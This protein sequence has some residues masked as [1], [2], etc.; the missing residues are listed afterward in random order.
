[1]LT[2]VRLF[3]QP[4][5]EYGGETL[6]LPAERRCQLLALLALRRTWVSRGEIADLFWPGLSTERA[7]TN[8]R[9]VVHL[10]R[11]LPWASSLELQSGALRFDVRNDVHDFH[12]AIAE[13]RLDDALRSRR[14][15]L[16][17]GFDADAGTGW[18]TWLAHER[19]RLQAAWRDAA[20]ARLSQDV[21]AAAAID[22]S[23]RLVDADGLDEAALRA[24]MLA[25]LRDGQA[26][27][28]R[29]AYRDFVDRLHDELGLPPSVELRALHDSLPSGKDA[30]SRAG[31]A[32]A[33]SSEDGFVGRGVELRQIASLLAQP[34]CRLV[35]LVGPGGVGKSRLARRS[36]A[37]LA[38]QFPD[39][40]VFVALEDAA[41]AHDA[42][43]RIARELDVPVAAKGDPLDH[44]VAYLRD[45]AMLLVLDNVEH[46]ASDASLLERLLQSC[47][48]LR[49]IVT[50]RV[51]LGLALEWLLPL[52]G[53]PFPEPEDEDRAD[54]FDAVR[55]FVKAARRVQPAF[56]AAAERDAIV[57][58][59]RQVEGLPLALEIAAAWTR[60]LPCATIAAE[61][62]EGT[63]LLRSVDAARPARQASIEAVF[64]HSW[65]LLTPVERDVLARL[66][67]FRGGFTVEAARAV[68]GAA[69]PVLAALADKS[70][71][72]NAGK[73]MQL[74]PLVHQVAALRL[75]RNASAIA[76][77]RAHAEYFHRMLTRLQQP[78]RYGD[79]D[80]LV[81]IEDELA[82]C[83]SAW[84]WAIANG[85]SDMLRRSVLALLDFFE[86]RGRFVEGLALFREATDAASSLMASPTLIDAAIAHLEYRLDRHA[87]AEARATRVLPVAR[88]EHDDEAVLQCLKTL[89][90]CALAM[91]RH[92]VAKRFFQQSGRR[93]LAMADLRTAAGMLDNEALVDKA[94]GNYDDALRLSLESLSRH[95]RLGDA[96]GVALCLNNVGTLYLALGQ[97]QSARVN[98]Q[99][100]LELCD[101]QGIV[102]TRALVLA[103]LADVALQQERWEE[104]HAACTRAL[105]V[106]HHTSN[107]T[108]VAYL[109]LQY[110]QIALHRADLDGA[111][112][113]L[114]SGLSVAIATGRER[115]QL[116]A[117]GCFGEILAAQAEPG[118]ARQVLRFA[119]EHPLTDAPDREFF[120]RSLADL[121]AGAEA[122]SHKPSL[123]LGELVQR[124]VAETAIAYRPLI[125]TLRGA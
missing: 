14:G 93:A 18:T 79:H 22:L 115:L 58:I 21:D 110:V 3:G 68:A 83:R 117:V 42:C 66:S 105:E 103:N 29:R 78:L 34:E 12:T 87:E 61:V 116:I 1:M 5:A 36:M 59:C 119:A 16:L 35:T 15:D 72:R 71:V 39:S 121:P 85:G 23:A 67:M 52:E 43:A 24:H 25:L 2:Y 75:A 101:R 104:A 31:S 65:R 98:L 96:A 41:Q 64:D 120:E 76:T 44:V 90:N 27:R 100:A 33:T 112:D 94:L 28:A 13:G 8:L 84:R 63:D 109:H 46:L 69:L 17:S 113:H 45:R 82:N 88:A 108:V 114:R 51:R 40:A 80:A 62:R 11:A 60:V 124:I 30:A 4:E 37:A 77:A 81:E 97:I 48:R 86:H 50:S 20:L 123:D 92:R 10:A 9:K 122:E 7:Y 55:L 26:A 73:R 102:G 57:D 19:E 70:L 74:H 54:G 106:A 38:S 125:A 6:A 107:R 99:E 118:C 49:I 89:G 111:R 95:R 47:P 53:L 56:D 91:A 32:S